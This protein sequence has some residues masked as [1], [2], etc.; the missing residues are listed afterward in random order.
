V[1]WSLPCSGAKQETSAPSRVSA[2]KLDSRSQALHFDG[3]PNL[4]CTYT[5]G[6]LT[7]DF[8]LSATV[9]PRWIATTPLIAGQS[10]VIDSST[11]MLRGMRHFRG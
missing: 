8:P 1:P 5:E 10:L 6:P 9:D 3:S 11:A 2:S 7:T 4:R